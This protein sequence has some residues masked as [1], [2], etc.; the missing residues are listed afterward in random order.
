MKYPAKL[1][2]RARSRS[3]IAPG[4]PEGLTASQT[5]SES[6]H[7]NAVEV[8]AGVGMKSWASPF[9]SLGPR[10]LPSSDP[11]MLPRKREAGGTGEPLVIAFVGLALEARIAMQSNVFVV[12]HEKGCDLATSLESALDAGCRSI[13]SFGFAGGLAPELRAGDLI[14]ASAIVDRH[15]IRPT[16][17]AWSNRLCQAL[18]G[19]HYMPLVGVDMPI[20]DAAARREL[21]VSAGAAAVDTESHFMARFATAHG[22]AFAALRV[23]IDP[24][25]RFVPEAALLAMRHDGTIDIAAMLAE[26]TMRPSQTLALLRLTVDLLLARSSLVRARQY[27]GSEA[28]APDPMWPVMRR[29]A[30][31]I[32]ESD[33]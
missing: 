10:P 22:M 33:R 25:H 2:A 30:E 11:V 29:H 12:C 8:Y 24:V 5:P 14:V 20:V 19:S 23:I 15:S 3:S 16:N 4:L 21:H 13:I 9:S 7:W 18:P 28:S 1:L 17:A 6:A 26:L 27:L 32:S 31:L